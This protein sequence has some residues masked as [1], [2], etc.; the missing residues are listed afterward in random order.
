MN[1]LILHI[2]ELEKE[3][4]KPRVRRKSNMINIEA[5]INDIETEKTSRTF[6]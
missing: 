5:E 2:K 1:N 6:R 3:Q 4:L